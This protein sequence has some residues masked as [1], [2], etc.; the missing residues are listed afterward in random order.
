MWW[1]ELADLVIAMKFYEDKIAGDSMN[2]MKKLDKENTFLISTGEKIF[3]DKKRLETYIANTIY[4]AAIQQNFKKEYIDNFNKFQEEFPNSSYSKYIKPLIDEVED[5]YKKQEE[6]ISGKIKFV[7]NSDEIDN[8]GELFSQFKGKKLYIDVWA[9][10]CGYCITEFKYGEELKKLLAER[11]VEILYLS[12]DEDKDDQKWLE[13]VKYYNLD[14]NHIRVND[15]FK[16]NLYNLY[17]SEDRV[18]IPKYIIVDE[19]GKIV[20]LDAPRPSAIDEL[21]KQL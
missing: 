19:A 17:G 21:R 7:K 20:N 12:I 5:F 8:T 4:I 14:G 10:W 18:S 3:S 1:A 15:S 9:T 11:D 16:R 13:M 6:S 2:V